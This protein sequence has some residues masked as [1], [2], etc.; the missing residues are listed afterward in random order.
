MYNPS[1]LDAIKHFKDCVLDTSTTEGTVFALHLDKVM[2]A[3]EA[4]Y[5]HEPDVGMYILDCIE[6]PELINSYLTDINRQV[7]KLNE[8]LESYNDYNQLLCEQLED[9]PW[10]DSTDA[11]K[12]K[13]DA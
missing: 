11:T 8:L 5:D 6:E 7:G 9:V 12:T 13:Q 2:R 1:V 3:I 4:V 10:D